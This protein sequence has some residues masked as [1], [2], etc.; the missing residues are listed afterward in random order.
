MSASPAL[1]KYSLVA[2]VTLPSVVALIA[3]GL[4]RGQIQPGPLLVPIAIAN[5]IPFWL[6]RALGRSDFADVARGRLLSRDVAIRVTGAW[7]V[8]CCA[9]TAITFATLHA[10]QIRARGAS[11]DPVAVFVSPIYIFIAGLGAYAALW[12]LTA[13]YRTL[14]GRRTTK[15]AT[16]ET[17]P[18]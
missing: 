16:N 17:R 13:L 5:A 14:S 10:A 8:M 6:L 1:L 9:A 18:R 3:D 7:V 15:R 11:T 2:G 4:L 12:A